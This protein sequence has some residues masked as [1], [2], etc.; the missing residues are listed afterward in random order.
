M[1]AGKKSRHLSIRE[2]FRTITGPQ[3]IPQLRTD[4]DARDTLGMQ[5]NSSYAVPQFKQGNQP[6]TGNGGRMNQP[7]SR[8]R[9]Q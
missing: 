6:A 9:R 7:T 3:S 8:R 2:S 1:A 5:S 4:L